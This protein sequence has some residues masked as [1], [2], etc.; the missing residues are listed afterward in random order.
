MPTNFKEENLEIIKSLRIPGFKEAYMNQIN[1]EQSYID[2]CFDERLNELL[3]S[4]KD[5]R[6]DKRIARKI[7]ESELS[8]PTA[9]LENIDYRPDRKIEK[10]RID[11]LRDNHYIAHAINILISGATGSGKSFLANALGVNAC[12]SSLKVH[13]YRTNQL[14]NTCEIHKRQ[15]DLYAF[16]NSLES[17]DLLILDDFLLTPYSLE[18]VNLFLEIF[19]RRNLKASTIVCSQ[20]EMRGWSQRLGGGILAESVID[21]IKNPSIRIQLASEKSLREDY[22]L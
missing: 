18:E 11:S 16:L 5:S 1:Q 19:E 13:Y 2:V 3:H 15:N 17:L 9:R 12:E 4:E 22:S 14:L 6:Y 8:Q 20:V 21:R 7:K 10:S